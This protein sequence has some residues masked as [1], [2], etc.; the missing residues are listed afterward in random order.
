MKLPVGFG[1]QQDLCG[2]DCFRLKWSKYV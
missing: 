1:K 2:M